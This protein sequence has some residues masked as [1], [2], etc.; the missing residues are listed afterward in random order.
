VKYEKHH[1]QVVK[2]YSEQ[3]P[4]IIFEYDQPTLSERFS[5]MYGNLFAKVILRQVIENNIFNIIEIGAGRGQLAY[6]ILN[7]IKKTNPNI[8]SKIKYKI[9]DVSPLLINKKLRLKFFNVDEI[10]GDATKLPF[11][12]SSQKAII[13]SNEMI[14]DLPS[15]K[16]NGRLYNSGVKVFLNELKRV[17]KKGI[18]NIVEYGK[19]SK[20]TKLKLGSG[21]HYHYEVG[22]NFKEFIYTANKLF[23]KVEY[24]NLGE[25]FNLNFSSEGINEK[26]SWDYL[27]FIKYHFNKIINII[28]ISKLDYFYSIFKNNCEYFEKLFFH[29]YKTKNMFFK[30]TINQMSFLCFI[31]SKIIG[32]EFAKKIGMKFLSIEIKRINNH[33]N[34]ICNAQIS[35]SGLTYFYTTIEVDF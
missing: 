31:L 18:I 23:K 9:V 22:I 21:R 28:I 12:N 20:S 16:I 1:R 35:K 26:F 14:A 5:P 2:Y 3:K 30:K 13:I 10:I 34:S 7:Y 19:L 27:F 24:G 4:E 17:L 6:D 25:F 11:K 29:I 8:F 15:E 33:F 32:R